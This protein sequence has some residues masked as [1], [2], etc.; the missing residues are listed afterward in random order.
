MKSEYDKAFTD[1]LSWKSWVFSV[2][3][4]WDRLH[5]SFRMTTEEDKTKNKTNTVKK[6]ES[7]EECEDFP[8][9]YNLCENLP[10]DMVYNAFLIPESSLTQ[11]DFLFGTA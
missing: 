10:R 7:Q 5:I 2:I 4:R 1:S 6:G 8:L 3:V 11:L 9:W